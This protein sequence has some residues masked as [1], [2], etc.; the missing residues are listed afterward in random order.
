MAEHT[1]TESLGMADPVSSAPGLH[2]VDWGGWVERAVLVFLVVLFIATGFLPGWQRL[3]SD[4]PNYYLI[5]RLYREGYPLERVYE[6]TWLQR[7]KD[8]R[9]IDQ[10]LVSFIPSTLPSALMVLPWSS[11]SSLQAKRCWLLVNLALLLLTA[12]LLNAITKLGLRRI[13]LVIFL[14]TI[15]LRDSFLLGQM[16]IFVLFL[17]TFAAYL[18]FRDC[19]F[20]AGIVLAIAATMKIYPALF[21][22]FFVFKKQWRA[23][24]GLMVGLV[25]ASLTSLYLF[26]RDACLLYGQE[27][28]PRGLRGET[29]DPYSV[30]WNSLSAL[31]RRLLIAEPELN[32]APVAHN[33][34]LYALL[35]P[36]VHSLIFV[37][38]MWAI[39]TKSD[40]P[41]RKRLEWAA[42]LFLLL[43]LSSQPGSYHF[44]A[45][46]LTSAVVIDY[47]LARRETIKAGV[48]VIVYALICGPL[49]RLPRMHATGWGNLM[50]FPRLAFMMLF[51]GLVL[52]VLLSL[53]PDSFKSRLNSRASLVAALALTALVVVGFISNRQHLR[54]QFDNYKSRIVT[55]S[56][57][58]MASD[59]VV[60]PRGLLFTAM[61]KGGYSIRQLNE[62]EVKNFLEMGGDWFHP[63]AAAQTGAGW[64]ELSSR[65]QSR[66]VRWLTQNSTLDSRRHDHRDGKR[67]AA[68]GVA[69]WSV[70]RLHPRDRRPGSLWIAR[71]GTAARQFRWEES[72]KL[73][74]FA[75]MCEE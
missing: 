54:G 50:F 29:I 40:E 19:L 41:D 51:G 49:V 23:A 36:L 35:H 57:S 9:G 69:R 6:W 60:T 43:L 13:A 46:I 71:V 44:V 37:A 42:Y 25:S 15:P 72:V 68:G 45:L 62:G 64:A 39:G 10:P 1:T 75:T 52:W 4:F 47:L 20:W 8:H 48:L 17:L 12:V 67:R 65:G 58:L 61:T 74:G 2:Q 32:P 16:H 70:S 56:D 24:L 5:A 31:L 55:I 22:I 30:G 66:I 33:P 3:N 63:T 21:L 14:A 53:S 18:Y 38:F 28:L 26:G 11:L 34:L 73:R 7:Q 27:I 59:A